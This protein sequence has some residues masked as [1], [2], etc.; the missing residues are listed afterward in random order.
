[1]GKLQQ[2]DKHCTGALYDKSCKW[3]GCARQQAAHKTLTAPP[4]IADHKLRA[5]HLMGTGQNTM[6]KVHRVVMGMQRLCDGNLSR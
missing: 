5:V 3:V 2:D 1:M 6:G 4:L